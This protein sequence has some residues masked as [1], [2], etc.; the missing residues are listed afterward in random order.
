[1]RKTSKRTSPPYLIHSLNSL[2]HPTLILSI[3]PL[4][5]ISLLIL[6]LFSPH[7]HPTISA[8]SLLSRHSLSF[9]PL[10]SHQFL[11]HISHSTL[12]FLSLT[13]FHTP[14]TPLFLNPFSLS[15]LSSLFLA[16]LL[17]HSL[18]PLYHHSHYPTFISPIF[19]IPLSQPLYFSLHSF[20]PLSLSFTKKSNPLYHPSLAP[21]SPSVTQHT[22]IPLSSLSLCLPLLFHPTLTLSPT[23]ILLTFLFSSY[24]L[25]LT[26]LYCISSSH[27]S[28]FPHFLTLL[29]HPFLS[30]TSL[31]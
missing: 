5:P 23:H 24:I 2:F 30:F 21:R 18:I 13:L 19:L 10:T 14:L 28:P 4:T 12:S 9:Y 26:P 7:S 25:T 8:Y 3:H 27:P 17:Q 16:L 22:L 29:S 1:M 20:T 15:P 31:T 6:P 11:N